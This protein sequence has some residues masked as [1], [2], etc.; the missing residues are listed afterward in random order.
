MKLLKK[1][2]SLGWHFTDPSDSRNN[3]FVMVIDCILNQNSRDLGAATYPS[4]NKGVVGLCMEYDVGLFQMPC[5]EM[6]FMGFKR[7]RNQGQSI[8]EALD[9]EEGRD[10]CRKL[11][12]DLANR[13]EDHMNN[14]NKIVAVLGG[15]PESPG[16]AIHMISSGKNNSMADSS[17]IFMKEF[18]QELCHRNIDVPFRG[19][20]DC[21]PESIKQDLDWLEEL[22]AFVTPVPH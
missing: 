2:M 20:R 22:F 5:P 4:M 17:G 15:N 18:H 10:C 11:S 12:V 7:K 6:A 16:C 1:I 3:R 19:M 21:R 14:N 9:T 13:I 8:R